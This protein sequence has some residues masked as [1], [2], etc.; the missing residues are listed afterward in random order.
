MSYPTIAD[1]KASIESKVLIKDSFAQSGVFERLPNNN[2][3]MFVG[4]F[5]VVFP[6][7]RNG[8][9]WAFRCWHTD[10]GDMKSRYKKI[11]HAIDKAKLSYFAK[12][13]YEDIGIVVNGNSYPTTRMRWISG[14]NIKE[15]ICK[16]RYNKQKLVALASNFKQMCES[17]H[18]F[19]LAHGDLQHGNILVSESSELF[20]VDYDSMH[21]PELVGEIDIITGLVDY[22]HPR[23]KFNKLT[24]KKN[25]YF[26]ELI[27][28][29]S[30][31]ITIDFP[32][33][34]EKYQ[35][36]QSE[37]M[38]FS[39]DD[40][41]HLS[42]SNIFSDLTSAQDEIQLLLQILKLYLNENDID[43]LVSFEI[44][45][46][47][48]SALPVL[49]NF[50]NQQGSIVF[51]GDKVILTWEAENVSSAYVNGVKVVDKVSHFE[52]IAYK[53]STY[54]LKLVNG[55]KS[56][57]QK[58]DITVI[59]PPKFKAI[60]AENYIIK[61][62]AS[63]TLKWEIENVSEATL[64]LSKNDSLNISFIG[65]LVVEPKRTTTYTFKVL[66]QDK[67]TIFE[68]FCLIEVFEEGKILFYEADMQF[69][70]Q[71]MPVTLSWVTANAEK[72]EIENFGEVELSGSVT[73]T[74]TSD[75][76]Y[77][78]IVTDLF[79]KIEQIIEVKILPLPLIEKI[80]IPTPNIVNENILRIN[81]PD[82]SNMGKN[83]LEPIKLKEFEFHIKLNS[84]S[85]IPSPKP[86]DVEY[87]INRESI[88]QK[89][90]RLYQIIKKEF[91]LNIKNKYVSKK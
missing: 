12:F 81:I 82:F 58:I 88:V 35:V 89:I 79:G 7:E 62:G 61:K 8:E 76:K 86:V 18:E 85:F 78:L 42:I 37:R 63:T 74:P 34:I 49:T 50:S 51:L 27:I 69:V 56:V 41:L 14:N 38:F 22:Q 47:K 13:E 1:I 67:K 36:E 90:Q 59:P 31:L 54:E 65:N 84:M 28:Y 16:N 70:M 91:T 15:F 48:L 9:N 3:K 40:F 68:E 20:L 30:I 64:Y 73:L 45:L 55:I 80:I 60:K 43:D 57:I 66:A 87:E 52:D 29:L 10:L 71:T 5:S 6:F 21:C 24:S 11:A 83:Y 2:L 4:G 72:V 17:M 25:D 44:L 32:S 75:T 26:S 39:Q 33:L 23:R 53:S 19:D 77:K 46:E